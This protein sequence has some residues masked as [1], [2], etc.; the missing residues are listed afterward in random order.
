MNRVISVYVTANDDLA[1]RL[2]VERFENFFVNTTI[3]EG[4]GSW[5]D[6]RN[7][8]WRE[9]V[10]IV[11]HIFDADLPDFDL[12]TFGKLL[13]AYKQEAEQETVLTLEY[14]VQGVLK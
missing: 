1:R 6:K 2:W 10:T 7:I 13:A 4:K 5:K 8:I 14:D 11:T 12:L 3:T 9:P